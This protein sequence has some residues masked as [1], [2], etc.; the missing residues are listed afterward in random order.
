MVGANPLRA[1]IIFS[2]FFSTPEDVVEGLSDSV[3][4]V[5]FWERTGS[6]EYEAVCICKKTGEESKTLGTYTKTQKKRTI[7]YIVYGNG[8]NGA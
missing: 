1:A 8:G 6:Q 3:L 2:F 7:G 4:S 5:I